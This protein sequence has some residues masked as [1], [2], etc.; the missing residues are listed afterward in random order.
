MNK[1]WKQKPKRFI[2][3]IR[4]FTSVHA[5]RINLWG[6]RNR[7]KERNGEEDY[8]ME[9]HRNEIQRTPKNRWGDVVL[10]DL[11]KLKMK[12]SIYLVKR[13]EKPGMT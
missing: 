10:N 5:H 11:H 7:M 6:H 13:M 3:N 2:P 4:F 12:N 8:G 9:C 1:S